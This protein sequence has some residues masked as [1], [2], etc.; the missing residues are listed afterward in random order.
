[1]L[2]QEDAVSASW[3]NGLLRLDAITTHLIVLGNSHQLASG[4]V[5]VFL[6]TM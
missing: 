2:R 4:L 5:K 1:M 6:S 3:T